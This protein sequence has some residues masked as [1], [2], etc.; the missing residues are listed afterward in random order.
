METV[1][2]LHSDNYRTLIKRTL[3]GDVKATYELMKFAPEDIDTLFV[4]VKKLSDEEL[5]K[6]GQ[7]FRKFP[8]GCDLLEL[9]VDPMSLRQ[10]WTEIKGAFR[11]VDRL[12]FPL[13]VCS[14]VLADWAEILG[15]TPLELIKELRPLADVPF[16]VDHF[17]R[18]GPMRYPKEISGCAGDCYNSGKGFTGCP[19]ARI[20]RRLIDKEKQYAD[21]RDLWFKEG[22]VQSVG[23]SL[24]AKQ[25]KTVHAAEVEEMLEVAETARKYGAGVGS[26]IA[27]GDGEEELLKGV[28]AI[29][30]HKIDEAVLEGGPYN[31]HPNRPRAFAEGVVMLRLL[32]P[33]KVV[34]TNGQYEDELRWGLRAGLN[35]VITGFP[36]NHHAYMSGYNP[37]EANVSKFGLP[38]VWEIMNEEVTDSYFEVPAGRRVA[39]II[40]KSA[41]FLE[42][43]LYPFA[44]IGG[45][46]IG[47]AHWVV[48]KASPMGKK[49]KPKITLSQ[50]VE[51]IKERKVKKLGLLGGRFVA[52]GIAKA[53]EGLVEEIV[54]SDIDP[55]IEYVTKMILSENL[56]VK[57]TTAGGDDE[58]VAKECDLTVLASFIPSL[59]KRFQCHDKVLVL[60]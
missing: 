12:G 31:R 39:E 17:G 14:Y 40:A 7:A 34:A 57:I 9:L 46:P 20:H 19:Y 41:M 18:Y 11:V 21:E 33:G 51:I 32:T 55:Y 37:G 26:I 28:K 27:V 2:K 24:F 13:H 16:D 54:I 5:F 1:K 52:W 59:V 42:D 22:V 25:R 45:I 4:E 15:K 30:E 50:L 36:G 53:V 3:E 8:F 56:N 60:D 48:L 35:S 29:Y 38:K 23:I 6:L 43:Y 10:S 47:D 44:E 58:K 49:N